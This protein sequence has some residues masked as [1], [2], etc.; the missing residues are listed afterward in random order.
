VSVRAERIELP[1]AAPLAG[2]YAVA[3]ANV[4]GVASGPTAGA[5]VHSA[6]LL[7]LLNAYLFITDRRQAGALLVLTAVPLLELIE[8]GIPAT[9]LSHVLREALVALLVL[10]VVIAAGRIAG[11]DRSALRLPRTAWRGQLATAACGIPLG[12][13]AWLILDPVP[14]AR[15]ND[16]AGLVLGSLVL[17]GL[18]APA[19]EL[20]FRWVLQSALLE[21]YG[22]AAVI[23]LGGLFAS[24]YLGTR[25][26]GF[27]ILMLLS[28][29]GL[30]L[31][32]MRTGVVWGA[33]GAHALLACGLLIIWPAVLG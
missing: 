3:A 12:L 23:L 2:V 11:I 22:P 18:T 15:S 31:Q 29:L 10:Y 20:L 21:L 9:P 19:L 32:T 17:V 26:P 24:L 8:L 7:A 4:I 33:V 16:A 28:G 14:L 5:I 27:V 30:S 25:S 6:V 1:A 13:L